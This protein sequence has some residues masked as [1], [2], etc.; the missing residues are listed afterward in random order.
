[1][2]CYFLLNFLRYALDCC[3]IY[4]YCAHKTES[5][6]SLVSF[7]CDGQNILLVNDFIFAG[8]YEHVSIILRLRL[9]HLVCLIGVVLPIFQSLKHP[10]NNVTEFDITVNPDFK[11]CVVCLISK[12][13]PM[14]L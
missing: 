11:R 4:H 10:D 6:F 5:V 9:T 7:I 2:L 14:K 12:K 13:V 8:I 3:K 1:M